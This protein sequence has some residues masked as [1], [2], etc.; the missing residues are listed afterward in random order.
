MLSNRSKIFIIKAWLLKQVTA[1]LSKFSRNRLPPIPAIA[2][3]VEQDNHLLVLERSDGMGFSLPGGIMRWNESIQ[4]AVK[5][6][7]WE[8]TGYEVEVMGLFNNYSG[9]QRDS[10][11]SSV[12]MAYTARVLNGK[13]TASDEG[14]PMWISCSEVLDLE[15]AFDA[16]EMIVDYLFQQQT[17]KKRER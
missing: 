12:C 16:R 6:E 1:G 3:I 10:R 17:L 15:L 4:D 9:P 13:L 8:E 7:V 5:R 14:K 2:A 11:F